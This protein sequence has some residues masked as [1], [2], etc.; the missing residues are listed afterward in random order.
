[1]FSLYT[2]DISKLTDEQFNEWYLRLDEGKKNRVDR[3]K[4]IDDKKRTVVA[5][6]LA[7]KAV[8]ELCGVAESDIH[9]SYTEKGKPYYSGENIHFNISHSSDIVV[10]VSSNRNIG[11]DVEKIRPISP[12]LVNRVCGDSELRLVHDNCGNIDYK[13]FFKIWTAKEA[14]FKLIGTGISNFKDVDTFALKN[15]VVLDDIDE[16]VISIVLEDK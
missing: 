6:A 12:Q 9:F 15:L 4:F 2:Y 8:C 7:R 5:D 1:M 11:V 13:S 16:Y 3:Y 10:C 14:Y